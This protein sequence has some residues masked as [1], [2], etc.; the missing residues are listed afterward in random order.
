MTNKTTHRTD[1]D[2]I[3]AEINR[4][5]DDV[6]AVY[7]FGSMARGDYT[8]GSDYDIAV[9]VKKYPLNDLELVTDI[10]Y[11]LVDAIKR[12]IDIVILDTKDLDHPSIFLYELYHNHKKIYGKADVLKK[13]RLAVRSVKPILEDGK[14]VGYHV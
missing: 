13:S 9:I 4:N 8:P 1:I 5:M 7:L 3:V 2:T 12:P 11:S 10:K 14:P 6:V